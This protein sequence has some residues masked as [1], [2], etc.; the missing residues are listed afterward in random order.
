MQCTTSSGNGSLLII[1]VYVRVLLIFT[2]PNYL[3][4]A[5]HMSCMHHVNTRALVSTTL[6]EAMEGTSI[7][8]E[9]S[10]CDAL[11][12]VDKVDAAARDG[13]SSIP[14]KLADVHNI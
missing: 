6:T 2:Q 10:G 12:H 4:A 11:G 3:R 5:L 7:V 14:Q 9:H 8:A 1:I 13:V